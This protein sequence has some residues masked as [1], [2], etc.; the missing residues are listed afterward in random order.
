AASGWDRTKE[1]QSEGASILLLDVYQ[2]G[3]A[4][5]DRPPS[6]PDHLVFHLSDDAHRVQDILT[7][8]AYLP[9]STRPVRLICD[10]AA[11]MWCWAASA[12]AARPVLVSTPGVDLADAER[13]FSKL[14]FVPGIEHA[15][16]IATIRR[17]ASSP[18]MSQSLQTGQ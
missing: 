1:L 2:T 13:D 7:G 9:A 18:Q 8:L 6:R 14:L 12:V 4:E 10:K 5:S 17:L 15:G 11:S 16:G 3:A